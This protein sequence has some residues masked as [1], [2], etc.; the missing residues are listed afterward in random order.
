V[1]DPAHF[2]IYEFPA[3]TTER[4]WTFVDTN[5]PIHPTLGTACAVWTGARLPVPFDYGLLW[6][7]RKPIRAHRLAWMIEQGDI[8]RGLFVLHKCDNP[9][10]VNIEHLF[11]GTHDDNMRDKQ[12]KGRAALVLTDA[13]VLAIR[14]ATGERADDIGARYG[15]SGVM[16]NLIRRGE[17]WDHVGGPRT[18][19][20]KQP[21][22]PTFKTR[23]TV[24]ATLA[25]VLDMMP[26]EDRGGSRRCPD[27]PFKWQAV[28]HLA[29]RLGCDP[30]MVYQTLREGATVD[31]IEKWRAL[32]AA[33]P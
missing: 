21:P 32:L 3:G 16:V 11:I 27:K 14:E 33:S 6:C 9:P 20:G 30:S 17:K 8:P 22:A 13:N 10:C 26:P 19:A 31:L 4:F 29:E 25:A 23:M 12:V 7:A 24:A 28:P 2:S 15:V 5:G 1:A 18:F